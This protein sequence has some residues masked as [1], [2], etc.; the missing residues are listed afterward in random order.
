M[1]FIM[2]MYCVTVA[3]R[4]FGQGMLWLSR[5]HKQKCTTRFSVFP[6]GRCMG[7]VGNVLEAVTIR[8]WL[9]RKLSVRRGGMEVPG[10]WS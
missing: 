8:G 3:L 4:N 2:E 6:Q 10:R 7:V 9:E 1:L 5:I